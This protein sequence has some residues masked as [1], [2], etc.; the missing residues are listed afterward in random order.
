MAGETDF[1]N[2]RIGDERSAYFAVAVDHVEDPWWE[3]GGG[4]D[5]LEDVGGKRCD[6]GG[7]E[8]EGIPGGQ[9]WGTFPEGAG[10]G[11]L[12]VILRRMDY[13]HIWIGLG[14]LAGWNWG[15]RVRRGNTNS[16]LRCRRI[17]LD[18]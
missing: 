10:D 17:R 15:L 12:G 11:G 1:C 5:L 8:D 4:E 18:H 2:A 9:R 16:M 14:S 7:L 13:A 6:L 3:A